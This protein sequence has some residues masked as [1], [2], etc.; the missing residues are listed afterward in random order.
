M[1][2]SDWSASV[3]EALD[4]CRAIVLIFSANANASADVRKEVARGVQRG[5][6]VVPIRIEDILPTKS[7]AY[8][9]TTVHW[10]DALTPPLE[11]HLLRLTDSIK[12]LR[13]ADSP[14]V[15]TTSTNRPKDPPYVGLVVRVGRR[16][17]AFLQQNWLVQSRHSS[18]PDADRCRRSMSWPNS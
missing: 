8:F 4:S 18:M 13:S 7:L 5:I 10:L 1:P 2:G 6:P 12:S 11:Q 9:M 17:R 3:V 15:G 16:T 14:D